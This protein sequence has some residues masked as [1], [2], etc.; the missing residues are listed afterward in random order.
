VQAIFFWTF[1]SREISQFFDKHPEL[2]PQV[3]APSQ[4]EIVSLHTTLSQQQSEQIKEIFCLFDTDGGGTMDRTELAVAMCALGLQSGR[5]NQAQKL[6][7]ER[8]I[9]TID[10]DHSN[11][12][13]LSE[14]QSL[15]KG[16]LTM[17]NPLQEI[18]AVYAGICSMDSSDPGQINLLKLRLATQK[19]QVK[20]YDHELIVMLDE[21]DYDGSKT[22]D[23]VEFIRIMNLSTWF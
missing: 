5:T 7:N 3:D 12:I 18:R 13:S 23:E 19:Y 16:E 9:N 2:K 22:V 14:F 21:V 4:D 17:S 15:M 6:S 1:L 10:S 11:S 20:L 8:M